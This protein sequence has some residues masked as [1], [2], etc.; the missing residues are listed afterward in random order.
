MSYQKSNRQKISHIPFL[1][2]EIWNQNRSVDWLVGIYY[3]SHCWLAGGN[4]IFQSLLIGCWEYFSHCWLSGGN[5]SVIVDWLVGIFQSLLIGCCEY[6]S[7]ILLISLF[8][9]VIKNT[10]VPQVV[11]RHVTT[12]I[13][14]FIYLPQSTKLYCSTFFGSLT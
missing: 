2:L 4:I 14:L 7:H 6:F 3:F 11:L 5:T 12:S 13:Q 8:V 1:K 10:Y 9:V